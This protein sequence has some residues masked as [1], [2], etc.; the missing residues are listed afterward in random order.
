MI[1]VMIYPVTYKFEPYMADDLDVRLPDHV[2]CRTTLNKLKRMQRLH[3]VSKE[4][5]KERDRIE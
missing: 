2:I 5:K 1:G 3:F 4:L